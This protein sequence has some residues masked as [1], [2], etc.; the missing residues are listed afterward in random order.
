VVYYNPSGRFGAAEMFLAQGSPVREGQKL[1]RI[2]DLKDMVIGVRV[3]EAMISTVRLGQTAA[4]RID[5]L[6]GKVF[7]GKVTQVSPVASAS[8]WMQKDVKVYPVTIAIED[9]PPILKPGM[10]GEA[11]ITTGERKAVLQVPLKAV[12]TLGKD[13][14]CY[15][16]S[17][18][19]LHERQVVTGA[20]NAS[21]VEIKDGLKEGD[22]V[23]AD[24]HA[25]RVRP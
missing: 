13:R 15:V 19:E 16:K 14:F 20:S 24:P 12:V 4:V 6:P 17:G 23:V 21:H 5:A 10:S 11:Q 1:L 8:D 2:T 9:A 25:I 3:H 7:R 22:Q 18:D